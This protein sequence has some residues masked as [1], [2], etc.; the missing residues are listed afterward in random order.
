MV[1]NMPLFIIKY[2]LFEINGFNFEGYLWS[3]RKPDFGKF[4]PF[5]QFL[6]VFFLFIRGDSKKLQNNIWQ[7][8][9]I[10]SFFPFIEVYVTHLEWISPSLDSVDN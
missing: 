5:S 2:C 7:Q 4:K 9:Q 6:V 10:A 8:T 1:R 3:H